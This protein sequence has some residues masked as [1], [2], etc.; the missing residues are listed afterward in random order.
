M[1][2]VGKRIHRIYVF[3]SIAFLLCCLPSPVWAADVYPN[4]PINMI[5]P[6]APGGGADLGSKVMADKISPFLGQ[7]ILSI[8]KPGGSGSLGASLVAKAKPDGYTLLVGSLSPLL[9]APIVKKLDYQLED[10]VFIALFGKGP[11]WLAVRTNAKWK[12]LRDFIRDAKASPGSL[13]VGSYGSLS[14]G[15]LML[16]DLSKQAKIKVNHVPFKSSGEAMTAL[17]GGHVDAAMLMNASGQYESGEIRILAAAV[18]E[19][20]DG[21][22]EVPIFKDFGFNIVSNQWVGLCAPKAT[23]KPIVDKLYD[24]HKKAFERYPKELKESLRKVEYWTY[25]FGPE[26]SMKKYKEEQ[27][28]LL[29]MATDLGAVAK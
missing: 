3:V 20:L 13:N 27:V 22:P 12:D 23:P 24:A 25:F 19:K 10:F 1:K 2:K 4:R 17:L 15:H 9:M 29:R 8:Y 6:F 26:E 11:I 5:V 16:E 18:D 7:P 28:N 21:L 14:V